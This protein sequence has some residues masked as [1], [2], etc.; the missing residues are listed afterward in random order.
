MQLKNVFEHM[1]HN[2]FFFFQT[3]KAR[4]CENDDFDDHNLLGFPLEK[5]ETRPYFEQKQKTK[6]RK[7][8]VLVVV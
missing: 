2:F 1:Y 4:E 3:M 8:Y 6:V 5:D 7:D